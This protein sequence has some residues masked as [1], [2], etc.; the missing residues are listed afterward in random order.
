[1]Y[2]ISKMGASSS[3]IESVKASKI[4][5]L[6]D[7]FDNEALLKGFYTEAKKESSSSDDVLCLNGVSRFL[8]NENV[9]NTVA[10]YA[11][12]FLGAIATSTS[13]LRQAYIT[14]N[15]STS[16]TETETKVTQTANLS[17]IIIKNEEEFK[18]F[19]QHLLFI[20]LIGY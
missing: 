12:P 17:D 13:C 19:L 5:D 18:L 6:I 10:L 14:M 7:Y 11:L 15:S 3:I 2:V 1:M 4:S 20:S 8:A 16:S 9:V